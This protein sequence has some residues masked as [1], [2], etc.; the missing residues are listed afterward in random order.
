MTILLRIYFVGM[1]AFVPGGSEMTV[2]LPD[3]RSG[4]FASDGEPIETHTA[5]LLARAADCSGDCKEDQMPMAKMLY[6][7]F[8]RGPFSDPMEYLSKAIEGGGVWELKDSDL[9]IEAGPPTRQKGAYRVLR[10]PEGIRAS[11]V[12]KKPKE[13]ESFDWVADLGR[14]V[15]GSGKIDPGL[16]VDRPRMGLLVARLRLT[17]GEFRTH[18]MVRAGDEVQSV[19][20]KTLQ[21]DGRVFASSAL[22]HWVVAEARIDL[23]PEDCKIRLL[24]RDFA[25]G[26][27]NRR[28]ELEP[29]RCE[30]ESVIE[31]AILNVPT[32]SFQP[33][34]RASMPHAQT[35][36]HFEVYY[37]LA[38]VPPDRRSRPV[39][40]TVKMKEGDKT[41]WKS[42]R[43]ESGEPSD[44]LES[45][46]L[47]SL[48]GVAS[49]L[50]CPPGQ[51]SP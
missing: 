18:R 6:S 47:E 19:E 35:G 16:L 10:S 5:F 38:S 49:P 41:F 50:L 44:F 23:T 3:I 9:S 29:A 33:V 8:L 17:E 37:E 20:F 25:S 2:L 31:M 27:E 28:M 42:L 24:E 4:Y 34:P 36:R 51:Y 1:I 7:G 39:P 12:P 21:G 45:I 22:A 11:S 26:A 15:P 48:R 32:S 43:S 14:I 40:H 30:G 46:V 13:R